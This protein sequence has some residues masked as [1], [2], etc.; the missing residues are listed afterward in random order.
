M[1]GHAQLVSEP[2]TATHNELKTPICAAAAAQIRIL[3][4]QR[5]SAARVRLVCARLTVLGTQQCGDVKLWQEG[6]LLFPKVALDPYAPEGVISACSE[7]TFG[8]TGQVYIEDGQIVAQIDPGASPAGLTS[9]LSSMFGF[10]RT[11]PTPPLT[12]SMRRAFLAASAKMTNEC[13]S[14]PP[15]RAS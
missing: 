6:I 12:S 2:N 8:R 7:A 1:P 10:R 3:N 5:Y 15:D 4:C 14:K 13:L 11:G 9:V